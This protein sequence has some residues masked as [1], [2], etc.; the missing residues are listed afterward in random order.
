MSDRW[1][2]FAYVDMEHELEAAQ[3]VTARLAARS[4]LPYDIAHWVRRLPR[5]GRRDRNLHPP[6]HRRPCPALHCRLALTSTTTCNR[7]VSPRTSLRGFA[8]RRVRRVVPPA[9]GDVPGT[10]TYRDGGQVRVVTLSP[11]SE[12]LLFAYL[13]R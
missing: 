4:Q 2:H 11:Q 13:G 1:L 5:P 9:V 6:P 10:L 3:A 7:Q 8:L 12:L